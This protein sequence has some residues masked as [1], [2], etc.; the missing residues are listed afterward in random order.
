MRIRLL[1]LF[2]IINASILIS[3]DY[4]NGYYFEPYGDLKVLI[5]C[6]GFGPNFDKYPCGDWPNED[7]EN[8]IPAQLK[9]KTTFYDSFDDFD[10]PNLKPEH[11]ILNQGKAAKH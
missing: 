9:N 6:V 5:I 11:I 1:F 3:G 10:N 8:D 4:K 2:F 7:G